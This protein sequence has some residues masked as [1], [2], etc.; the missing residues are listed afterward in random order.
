[1]MRWIITQDLI[2]AGEAVGY[3]HNQN[4]GWCRDLN[5]LSEQ[6]PTEIRLKDDDGEVY[7]IGLTR[8][9]GEDGD[10]AFAPLDWAMNHAGATTLEHRPAHTNNAWETL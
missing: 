5:A 1:M 7:Y 3:G 10:R 8:D 4:G 6:M 9:I 2:G